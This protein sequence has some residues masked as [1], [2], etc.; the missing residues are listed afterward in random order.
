MR[1][2]GSDIDSVV[3]Q[4]SFD[5]FQVDTYFFLPGA[6]RIKTLLGNDCSKT[7]LFAMF[8]P[9]DSPFSSAPLFLNLDECIRT[10][11]FESSSL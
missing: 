11:K 6:K 1:G 10:D 8:C 4:D 7:S 3:C 9:V 2:D 5:V